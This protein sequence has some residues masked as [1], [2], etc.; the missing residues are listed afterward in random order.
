[1]Y[2]V[3]MVIPKLVK[4]YENECKNGTVVVSYCFEI[5]EWKNKLIEEIVIHRKSVFFYQL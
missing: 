3:P 5:R 2:P 4:K 1:M